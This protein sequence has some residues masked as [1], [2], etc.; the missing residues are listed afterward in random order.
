MIVLKISLSN[1]WPVVDKRLIGRKF[2]VFAG[3][4]QSYD[5]L[6]PSKVPESDQVEG[7]D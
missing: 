4:R 1:N 3:F 2:W 6:S 7:G 5:F